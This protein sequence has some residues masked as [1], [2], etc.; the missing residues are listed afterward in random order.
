MSRDTSSDERKPFTRMAQ[1]LSSGQRSE[2]SGYKTPAQEINDGTPV[3]SDRGR[4]FQMAVSSNL[5]ISFNC[6][7]FSSIHAIKWRIMFKQWFSEKNL[8]FGS[9]RAAE[10]AEIV[11]SSSSPMMGRGKFLSMLQRGLIEQPSDE[12]GFSDPSRDRSD[13]S[14]DGQSKRQ[15]SDTFRPESGKHHFDLSFHAN[16]HSKL[17]KRLFNMFW[18]RISAGRGQFL[19]RF[20]E[21]SNHFH[22]TAFSA[23]IIIVDFFGA[24]ICRYKCD[25][26]F[27]DRLVH[28]GTVR[29][30]SRCTASFKSNL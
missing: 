27:Y 24:S 2:E 9:Q 22:L 8:V 30:N 18:I 23:A 11:S 25:S 19:A 17:F 13:Q 12:T 7:H 26:Y 10:P 5:E 4:F 1:M 6:S 28:F 14:S 3:V 20:R 21:V 15:S 29:P 16:V